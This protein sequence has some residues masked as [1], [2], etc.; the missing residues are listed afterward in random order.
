MRDVLGTFAKGC[1]SRVPLY[2]CSAP[3][4]KMATASLQ[5]TFGNRYRAMRTA[6]SLNSRGSNT[7]SICTFSWSKCRKALLLESTQGVLTLAWCLRPSKRR[8][9]LR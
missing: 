7:Y 5:I 1:E 2:G 6:S 3:P 9:A 8:R 4:C